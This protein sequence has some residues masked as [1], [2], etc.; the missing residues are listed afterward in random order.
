MAMNEAEKQELKDQIARFCQERIEPFME[1]DDRNEVFR[2]E[3]YE[4]LGKLGLCGMTLPPEYGGAGLLLQ[5]LCLALQEIAQYSV[6]YGVSLSVSS[7][8]QGLIN[9]FGTPEQKEKYLPTLTSGQEIGSFC[10]SE[11]GAGS[12]AAALETKAKKTPEGYLLKGNK[13][14]TS[15]AGISQ[16]YLVFARVEDSQSPRASRDIGA[17]IVEKGSEGL[18]FGKKERKMGWKTSPTREVIFNNC[19]VPRENCLSL[20]KG[21]KMAL[22]SLSR[23]R[24]TIASMAVGLAQRAL[25]EAVQ[26]SLER[27]QFGSPLF[28]FQGLQFMMADMATGIEASHLL[29]ERAAL[30]YDQGQP[31]RLLSSMA[32]LKST[33]TCM[34]VTTDAVQ[35]LGG[36]GYTSEYPVER[37]MRDAKAL[38]IVEGTNQIQRVLIARELKQYYGG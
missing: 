14:W 18:E 4:D 17:F 20:K 24:I 9:E 33:D 2:K 27:E 30:L 23:G 28:D 1:E 15:T 25:R 31:S 38:Q 19:L 12:D 32:K 13:M 16:V 36:V 11:A 21:L 34:Q 8:V 37:M 7:M 6:P 22:G 3:I 29:V 5:D 10:L 35:I 26:Y